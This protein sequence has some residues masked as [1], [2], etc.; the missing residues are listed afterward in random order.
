[1]GGGGLFKDQNLNIGRFVVPAE[2]VLL[3]Q[4]KGHVSYS[5][6]I[7]SSHILRANVT[8]NLF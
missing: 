3:G 8:S 5:L 2:E 4:K 7:V 6:I 1:M